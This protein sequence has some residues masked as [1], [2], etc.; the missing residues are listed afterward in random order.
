MH[1]RQAGVGFMSAGRTRD[2]LYGFLDYLS[3]KGLIPAA[4]ARARKA[5]AKQVLSMLHDDEAADVLALDID[6]LMH[7]FSTKHG[8]QYTPNSV[9]DYGSRLRSSIE[10]FRA[11]TEN[12][13]GFRIPGRNRQK[14]AES[15]GRK[16]S[17]APN[18]ASAA[19]GE[20]TQ[21][22]NLSQASGILPIPLR[23]DLTVQIAGLPFD[24]TQTEAKK[25]ANIVL[26]HATDG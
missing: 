4:T 8:Q 5:S 20:H 21:A 15:N 6:V 11:Y 26:A 1:E 19:A 12:P 2:D 9:R 7:R 23:A 18:P 22:S 14:S 13:L 24:L 17:K 3:A 16:P 25:I 10:D